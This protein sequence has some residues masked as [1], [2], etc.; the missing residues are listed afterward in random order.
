MIGDVHPGSGSPIRILTC[1]VL[2]IHGSKR[3]WIPDPGS[4]SSTLHET[5]PSSIIFSL[6]L[7]PCVRWRWLWRASSTSCSRRRPSLSA[8]CS[9]A[10]SWWTGGTPRHTSYLSAQVPYSHR[11]NVELDLLSLFGLHVYSCTHWLRPRNYHPPPPLHL[12]SYM[13]ALLVSQEYDISL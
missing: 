7:W 5:A 8:R 9:P 1:P 13:N 6:Y 11:L 10:L 12:G 3:H 2:R 4:G